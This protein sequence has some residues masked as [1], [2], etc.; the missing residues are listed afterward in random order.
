MKG[1]SQQYNITTKCF[2]NKNTNFATVFSIAAVRSNCLI[3]NLKEKLF[4]E[5]SKI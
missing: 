1:N 4:L 5:N 3:R 2:K